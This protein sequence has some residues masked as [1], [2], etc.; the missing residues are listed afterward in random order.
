[1]LRLSVNLS[2]QPNKLKENDNRSNNSMPY[3]KTISR[4]VKAI[5]LTSGYK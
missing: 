1:M 2:V 3:Q 4:G 5:G